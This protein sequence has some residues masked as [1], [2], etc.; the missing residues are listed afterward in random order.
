[1]FIG[2]DQAI[3]SKLLD[4]MFQKSED[5]HDVF[6]KLIPRMGFHIIMCMLKITFSRFKDSGIIKL[7]V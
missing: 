1:M 3:Y 4:V 2:V 6:S 5:G 7:F